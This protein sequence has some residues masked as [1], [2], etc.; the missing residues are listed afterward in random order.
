MLNIPTYLYLV[1]LFLDVQ[2]LGYND[3]EPSYYSKK[4]SVFTW[5]II[6]IKWASETSNFFLCHEIILILI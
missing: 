5:F 2:F 3:N 6:I 4:Q 1:E